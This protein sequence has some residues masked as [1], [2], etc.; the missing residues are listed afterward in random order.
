MPLSPERGRGLG[1]GEKYL[2]TATLTPAFSLKGEG[3]IF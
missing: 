3:V 2:E 1:R